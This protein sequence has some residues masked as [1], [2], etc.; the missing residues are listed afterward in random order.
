MRSNNRRGLR[1]R[2]EQLCLLTGGDFVLSTG[3]KSSFYFDCKKVTLDGET[4][5]LI[6]DELLAEIAELPL[7]PSGVA[8]LTLGAD[9]LVTAVAMRS[10]QTGGPIRFASIVRK[11][12]KEHG[13]RTMIENELPIGTK[14]VVIDDVI[15]KGVSI[16]QACTELHKASYEVVGIVALI[17]RE[18]GGAEELRRAY[19]C[20]VRTLFKKS[21][22]PKLTDEEQ[23]HARP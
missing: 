15:T 19:Q 7:A 5:T 10:C 1:D 23:R 12:P 2:I 16:S 13:T 18:A 20:P 6:A 17:D 8:G 21:D 11:A 22:F 14:V 4:A 9:P 3:E